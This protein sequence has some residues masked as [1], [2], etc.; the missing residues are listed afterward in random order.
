MCPQVVEQIIEVPKMAEEIPDVLVPE[1]V[2]QLVKLPKTVSEDRIQQRTA[3][4][5]VD[6]P[7]PQDVEET[8]GGLQGFFPR[9]GNNSVLWSRPMKLLI[10]PTLRR[11]L[12]GLSLRR[13]ERRNRP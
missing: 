3:E 5:I 10:F 12:R 11:S 13:K 8:G 4:R 6:I 7:V 1:M 9:T 2:E